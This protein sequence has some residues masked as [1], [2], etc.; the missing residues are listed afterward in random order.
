MKKLKGFGASGGVATGVV[1]IVT[2]VED[3]GCFW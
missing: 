3:I 1:K 2:S